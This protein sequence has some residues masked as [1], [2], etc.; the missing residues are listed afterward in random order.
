MA[1]FR[2]LFLLVP[3]SPPSSP[4][5]SPPG[6]LLPFNFTLAKLLSRQPSIVSWRGQ[7]IRPTIRLACHAPVALLMASSLIVPEPLGLF[8]TAGRLLPKLADGLSKTPYWQQNS[9]SK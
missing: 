1:L 2:A 5:T 8:P 7:E 9:P 6:P 3:P 4:N